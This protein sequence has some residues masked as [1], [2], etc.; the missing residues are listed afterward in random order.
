M[1]THSQNMFLIQRAQ[2]LKNTKQ[3][4]SSVSAFPICCPINEEVPQ[5]RSKYVGTG[6]AR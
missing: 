1:K 3:K 6:V 2:C 4:V 5:L